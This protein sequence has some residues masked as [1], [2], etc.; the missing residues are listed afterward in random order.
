MSKSNSTRSGCK[1]V[2]HAFLLKNAC[3]AGFLEI[4]VIESIETVPNRIISFS[5][6]L[7]TNDY[8]QWVCFYE[9]DALFE[10]VWNNPRK[11]LPILSKFRGII[12]PDFSLYYD[13]P[14]AMQIWNIFRSRALG[15][16]F[17]NNGIKVIANIRWGDRR[18]H[19]ICCL[20]AP[21]HSII[22][23]GSVGCIKV[24][25][26]RMLFVA[27]LEYIVKHLKPNTIIVYGTAPD[28]IFDKYRQLG[29]TILQFDS[30]TAKVFS[31]GDA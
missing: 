4:P 14:L 1:D 30:E 9:D 8:D 11:Y 25:I 5:K 27:G 17:Q 2:F 22:A 16:W 31:G 19:F 29:I 18:T 3:Y 7:R 10:R 24:M 15:H 21:K 13:M 23:V 20:G 28:F 6:A 26:N 12:T